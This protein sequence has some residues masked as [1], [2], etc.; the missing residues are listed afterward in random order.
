MSEI[1]TI[2][3]NPVLSSS[4]FD[5]DNNGLFTSDVNCREKE[6]Y[7][8]KK[9]YKEIIVKNFSSA[10]SEILMN[11]DSNISSQEVGD[12]NFCLIDIDGVLIEDNLVKLPFI[13]NFVKP[14]IP[15]DNILA[16]KRL[17]DKFDGSVAISTNRSPNDKVIFHTQA[18]LDE[19]YKSLKSKDINVPVFLNLFKQI[20]VMNKEDVSKIYLSSSGKEIFDQENGNK[21]RELKEAL[22]EQVVQ[23]IGKRLNESDSI[24]NSVFTLYSIEDLSI[25]SPNRHTYLKYLAKRLKAKRTGSASNFA[26]GRPE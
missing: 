12:E 7:N 5:K 3:Y 23:Y 22:V 4:N 2:S 8:E 20:P 26:V 11:V 15:E 25:V 10:V 21:H 16:L 13:S 9:K 19:L 18:V 6:N 24:Y 17:T 14:H 1:E